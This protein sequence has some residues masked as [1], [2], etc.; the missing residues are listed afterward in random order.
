MRRAPDGDFALIR[1]RLLRLGFFY[2][3][4]QPLA[5]KGRVGNETR[6]F[7]VADQVHV[8][9]TVLLPL[10]VASFELSIQAVVRM[11]AGDQ[12]QRVEFH[13][14]LALVDLARQVTWT[15]V[16]ALGAVAVDVVYL[17]TPL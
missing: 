4:G 1:Q 2:F 10:A 16:G 8:L 17:E 5:G 13:P 11:P 7:G 3:A 12:N 9:D 14:A 6:R 15:A